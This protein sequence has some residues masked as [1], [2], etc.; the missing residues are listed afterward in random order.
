MYQ[1]NSSGRDPSSG[2]WV[3]GL[4]QDPGSFYLTKTKASGGHKAW[5]QGAVDGNPTKKSRRNCI[6]GSFT[7]VSTKIGVHRVLH[8]EGRGV[9]SRRRG[10]GPTSVRCSKM[11]WRWVCPVIV[12]QA[13]GVEGGE[14]IRATVGRWGS[15]KC[16]FQSVR[17]LIFFVFV[18][19]KSFNPTPVQQ[20]STQQGD[21]VNPPPQVHR[22]LLL[23]KGRP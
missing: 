15:G 6:G 3:G 8:R 18:V 9:R 21:D 22:H 14:G 19:G 1:L 20:S 16:M 2:R 11:V 23:Y 17:I 5:T 10:L 4:I 7:I 12:A 13:C